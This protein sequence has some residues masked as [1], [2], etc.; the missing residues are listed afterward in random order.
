MSKMM[1]FM[2]CLLGLSACE[3]GSGAQTLIYGQGQTE[4]G[5]LDLR[6]DF[7][8]VSEECEALRPTVLFMH[9][10]SFTDG[11]R[12]NGEGFADLFNQAGF[13]YVSIDYRKVGD[14]PVANPAYQSVGQ[15]VAERASISPEANP[16]VI[17][18]AISAFEDAVQAMAF[19][20]AVGDDLCHDA[21]RLV[22]MGHSAGA[23]MALNVAYTLDNHGISRPR[24]RGVISDCGGFHGARTMA[25]SDV[26]LLHIHGLQDTIVPFSEAELLWSDARRTGT[27]M[28]L[29]TFEEE[30][31]CVP[32]EEAM[33]DGR[34]VLD[35]MVDFATDVVSGRR[36][37]TQRTLD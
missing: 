5:P 37:V 2:A 1:V 10:G 13:N 29:L 33:A 27:A 31:H 23:V 7:Y 8:P 19:L 32:L 34:P 3:G 25:G 18:A 35:W 16:L 30:G 4:D 11:S 36:P 6:L 12:E 28:Q 15:R 21:N 26:P 24:V 20:R 9:G 17:N 14:L 22:L